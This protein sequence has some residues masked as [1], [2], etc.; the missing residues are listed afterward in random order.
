MWFVRSAAEKKWQ[1][2]ASLPSD[3]LV[4]VWKSFNKDDN[5]QEQLNIKNCIDD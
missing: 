1:F 4:D 3:Q 5:C 2:S